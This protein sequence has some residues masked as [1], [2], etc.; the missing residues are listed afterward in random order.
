M[1]ECDKDGKIAEMVGD[2]HAC[3]VIS[4]NESML[5][6]RRQWEQVVAEVEAARPKGF[7]AWLRQ[8]FMARWA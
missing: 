1:A 2:M 3:L 4:L 8:A 5:D 6:A 7:R